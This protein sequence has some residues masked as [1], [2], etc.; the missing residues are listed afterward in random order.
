MKQLLFTI[1]LFTLTSTA[2]QQQNRIPISFDLLQDIT[3][4]QIGSINSF[5]FVTDVLYLDA[6]VIRGKL[7]NKREFM[8]ML[9]CFYNARLKRWV[10]TYDSQTCIGTKQKQCEF[11][12]TGC[13]EGAIFQETL[14]SDLSQ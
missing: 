8:T 10:F 11:T 12:L 14:Q 4:L 5:E 1:F 9:N 3:G 7:K 13:K 6:L 2:A